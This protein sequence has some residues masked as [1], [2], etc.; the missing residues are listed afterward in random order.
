L[1]HY[2]I[3]IDIGGTSIKGALL[4]KDGVVVFLISAP[5]GAEKGGKKVLENVLF[6]IETLIGK[7]GM[8]KN[9]IGVGI[10]TPGSINEK[11]TVIGGAKN[12]PGW[13]G[14]QVFRP[15]G[16]RFGLTAIAINDALAMTL[17]EWR[18]GAAKGFANVVCLSLGTGIG[19]GIIIDNRIYKGA[20]GLAGELGHVSVDYS[21]IACTCGQRGCVERYASA[22]GIVRTAIHTCAGLA[23]NRQTPFSKLVAAKPGQLTSRVVYDYVKKRD[24]IALQVNERVCEKLA[25][26]IGVAINAFAPDRVV[27]GGGVMNAGTIIIN[28]TRKYVPL[29]SLS[30]SREGC[31]LLKAKCGENAGAIGAAQMVFEQMGRA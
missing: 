29:Y 16:K 1:G 14:T 5:T 26:I 2:A 21:G 31:T 28:T 6:L 10:G 18:Y 9:I 20:H 12:L 11:G 23:K 22:T 19:G 8:K 25:R 24:R 7:H 27:L 30:G 4:S 3:G 15:I 13:E 17:A